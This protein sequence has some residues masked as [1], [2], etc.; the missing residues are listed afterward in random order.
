M[1]VPYYSRTA[2]LTTF[3]CSL[4]LIIKSIYK[5]END[6]FLFFGIT[7]LLLNVYIIIRLIKNSSYIILNTDNKFLIV[8]KLLYSTKVKLKDIKSIKE[9]KT[10]FYSGITIY[11]SNSKT[12]LKQPFIDDKF[13]NIIKKL[14][15]LITNS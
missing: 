9:T 13:N 12:L 2:Y 15:E 10:I 11:Y 14:S 1:K 5:L 8:N 6:F 4:F 7:I 3:S